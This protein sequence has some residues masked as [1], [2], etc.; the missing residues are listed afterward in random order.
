MANKA[1]ECTYYNE[2]GKILKEQAIVWK[3]DI[4]ALATQCSA[5]KKEIG[6][7]A[8]WLRTADGAKGA[9]IVYED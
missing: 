5:V 1:Y 8:Y 4:V 6:A 3:E 2:S 9:S 7:S